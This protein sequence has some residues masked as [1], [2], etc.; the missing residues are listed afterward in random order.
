MY[1][2]LLVLS[3]EPAMRKWIVRIPRGPRGMGMRENGRSGTKRSE[4]I[5]ITGL[6]SGR[7]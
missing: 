1:F 2:K 3:L 7:G 5:E 6:C 4:F